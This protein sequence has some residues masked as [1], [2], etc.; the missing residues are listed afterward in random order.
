MSVILASDLPISEA[1][2]TRNTRNGMEETSNE[3]E[4]EVEKP[5][6]RW[7]A[8][9]SAMMAFVQGNVGLFLIMGSQFCFA[10]MNVAVKFLNAIDPPVSPYEVHRVPDPWIG[11]K[12]I[13][14]MLVFRGF[15]GFFGLF[16]IYYSLQYLSLSDS[17]A[18]SFL[19]PICVGIAGAI[20]LGEKYSIA[21]GLASVCA[22]VG[23][24]LIARPSFLFDS[25]GAPAKF[26][27]NEVL[28]SFA[29]PSKATPE[30]RLFAV[31]AALLGVLGATGAYISIAAMGKKIHPMHAM[32][33]FSLQ[34]VLV[35]SI[36]FG[37]VPLTMLV[38]E[39]PLVIPTDLRWLG[40]LILIG[41]FGFVAQALLT[42]GLLRESAGKGSIAIYTQIVFAIILERIFFKAQ[43]SALSIAG[44][45][46]IVSSALYVAVS[47]HLS[48]AARN[49]IDRISQITKRRAVTVKS[50]AR[51]SGVSE[52]DLEEGL[53]DGLLEAHVEE[54]RDGDQSDRRSSA[55]GK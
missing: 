39:T 27:V 43:P 14:L 4:N 50:D 23:A 54:E 16:G 46:I 29:D 9:S 45:I 31:G 34:S 37:A 49:S 11:P 2:T 22:L 44:T 36:A 38:T 25:T 12:G 24:I 32:V 42:S 35:A 18:L 40:L 20:L 8:W 5:I 15:S 17:T 51:L 52:G 13:R 26:V 10:L 33:S 3:V 47:T 48:L 28:I 19:S 30:Q 1:Q 21:Q 7:R 53:L 6:P 55:T 41:V